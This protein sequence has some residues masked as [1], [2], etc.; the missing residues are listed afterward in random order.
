MGVSRRCDKRCHEARRPVCDCWCSGLFHGSQGRD[1]REAFASTFG[2]LPDAPEPDP[3]FAGTWGK[4]MRAARDA[5]D[6]AAIGA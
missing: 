6:G 4:A 1:A 2:A 5:S 3:L